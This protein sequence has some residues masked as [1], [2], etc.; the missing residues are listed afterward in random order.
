[1]KHSLRPTKISI[2]IALIFSLQSIQSFTQSTHLKPIVVEVNSNFN[3]GKSN[4]TLQQYK[5]DLTGV[6]AGVSFQAGITPIFSIVTETYFTMKGAA[7]KADNPVTV[8]KSKLRLYNAEIPVLARLHLKHFYINAGPYFSYM[9][10]GSLKTDG[11]KE[12]PEISTAITFHNVANGFKHWE[13]GLQAGA[14]Y[15]FRIKRTI[16]A[17]DLRYGY[18][19]TNI[20]QDAEKY[21]RT[22]N[23]SCIAF[24]PW[25]T[26]PFARKVEP[27]HQIVIK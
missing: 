15:N 19:L 20:S 18:G 6:L 5:K 11:S 23:I 26:N 7:L 25:K 9:I 12:V 24:K 10:G 22:F 17:L 4:S 21:N 14:G 2:A 13:M 8:N 16:L 27:N 3:Y 1:M